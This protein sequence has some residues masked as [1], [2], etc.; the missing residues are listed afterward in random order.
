MAGAQEETGGP[1]RKL[2][3]GPQI[4]EDALARIGAIAPALPVVRVTDD[5][6]VLADVDALWPGIDTPSG[7]TLLRLAPRLRWLQAFGAG[8]ERWL[9][10]AFVQRDIVL[11]NA[12][13]IHGVQIAEHTLSLL[14]AFARGLPALVRG[15]HAPLHHPRL[16]QFELAGQTLA[17]IGFGRIGEALAARAAALGLTVIGVRRRHQG[18][19]PAGVTR[20][21]G[22]AALPQVL[23]VADHVVSVLPLTPQTRGFFD[24]GR[25]ARFKPG[26]HF[27]NVGRGASVDHAA[28][29]RALADGRIAGA[30][31]DVT[32]P[33][34]L[35]PDHP[36]RRLPNVLL[37]AHTAGAS[38]HYQSRALAI[39]L[40][41]LSRFQAGQPLVNVVDKR[42]GY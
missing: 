10:P 18:A 29:A 33:E 1:L 42:A 35:P 31:L 32:D 8:V 9:T 21:A 16:G 38:P 12:S 5:W 14:L 19:L 11:T 37:T 22:L 25:F 26:S 36:L 3:V 40:D 15:Q 2:A 24:A 39:A 6:S 17:I 4:G 27:Y 13:G 41:N 28:L 23:A 30:G 7:D 34:P 20:L